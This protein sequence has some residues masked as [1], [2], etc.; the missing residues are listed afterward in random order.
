MSSRRTSSKPS[1]PKR[2]RA[3][4]AAPYRRQYASIAKAMSALGATC[5][6]L[7]KA[8]EVDEFTI[9]H[10][11]LKHKDFAEACQPDAESSDQLVEQAL[12]QR[13]LGYDR[14]NQK[15]VTR[16]GKTIIVEYVEHIPASVPAEQF[17]LVNRQSD[18]W[19]S[20]AKIQRA[21][22]E[23]DPFLEYLRKIDGNVLRPKED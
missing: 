23:N 12:K 3:Q 1:N 10:W 9:K 13:A 18:R 22:T 2:H 4:K 20:P 21:P 14:K 6:D 16:N 17:W 7:A 8:F 5:A 15:V 11:Q 19:R